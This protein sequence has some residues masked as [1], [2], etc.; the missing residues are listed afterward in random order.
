VAALLRCIYGSIEFAP[1]MKL[2]LEATANIREESTFRFLTQLCDACNWDEN[3][4]I[5]AKYLRVMRKVITMTSEDETEKRK[6]LLHYEIIA[7]V[8]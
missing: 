3:Y 6:H 7:R 4:N 8:I 1:T 5:G 2:Q